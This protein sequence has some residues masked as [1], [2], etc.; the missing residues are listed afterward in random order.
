MA[1]ETE[2]QPATMGVAQRNSGFGAGHPRYGGRKKRTAQQA[3]ELAEELGVDPL[4]FLM[5]IVRSD[6]VEQ[7]V[8][9]EKGKKKKVTTAIPLEMRIDAAKWVSRFCYPV[10]SAT[11]VTGANE[12]PVEIVGLDLT[13][14]MMDPAAQKLAMQIA[15]DTSAAAQGARGL[16]AGS[17]SNLYP[18]AE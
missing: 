14:M 17:V 6:T 7:T 9:D 1:K 5:E 16:S 18:D 15:E 2:Q 8:I 3:R 13:R 10:L 12:G 11:Q 4:R